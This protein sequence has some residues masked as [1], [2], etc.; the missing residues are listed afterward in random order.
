[1]KLIHSHQFPIS[2][3]N[4]PK[5]EPLSHKTRKIPSMSSDWLTKYIFQSNYWRNFL[6]FE[7]KILM[8]QK[9]I[10]KELL[11]FCKD[12]PPNCSAGQVKN[13][14]FTWSATILGPVLYPL[15]TQKPDT[16]Y[17]GGIFFLT[18]H[19]PT[20]YPFKSPKVQFTT[21]IYHPNVNS[22]GAICLDILKDKW[23]PAL[24]VSKV[25]LSILSLL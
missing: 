5:M 11:D 21:K 2:T 8:A 25:L 1:M 4:P 16:P 12:P 19:F 17:E 20:D 15:L 7:K 23:S 14:I 6:T 10:Q 9:R 18:I 22:N 24:T 13:D 3:T